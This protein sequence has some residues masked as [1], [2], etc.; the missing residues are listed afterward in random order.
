LPPEAGGQEVEPTSFVGPP[1]WEYEDSDEGRARGWVLLLFWA[2]I[3]AASIAL[4][5]GALVALRWL[6]HLATT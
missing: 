4:G 6:W 1:P 3:L 2:L 5:L